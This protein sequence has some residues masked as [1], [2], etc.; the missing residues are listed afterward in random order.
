MLPT[1]FSKKNSGPFLIFL[2]VSKS[3]EI[4]F[5]LI[6]ILIITLNIKCENAN[7][8]AQRERACLHCLA[9]T[10]PSLSV[11]CEQAEQSGC[12]LFFSCFTWLLLCQLQISLEL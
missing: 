1:Y 11:L 10:R 6:T 8:Y 3:G 5:S 9:L 12:L 4:V 7:G 2:K